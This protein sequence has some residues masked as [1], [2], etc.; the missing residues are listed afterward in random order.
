MDYA[1]VVVIN[2]CLA[3][4]LDKDVSHF[5]DR[6]NT[7][8]NIILLT[9]SGDGLWLPDKRGRDF[10]AISGASIKECDQRFNSHPIPAV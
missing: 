9:T 10:D 6:Q 8:A 2:S 4:G 7:T 5:L 1:A 3:W